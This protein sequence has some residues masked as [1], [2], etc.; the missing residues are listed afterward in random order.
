MG[1]LGPTVPDTNLTE[2]GN[3]AAGRVEVLH[4]KQAASLDLCFYP[5][6]DKRSER[7]QCLGS[8]KVVS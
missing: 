8:Q 1:C 2:D 5:D 7:N 3:F 6:D 4:Q